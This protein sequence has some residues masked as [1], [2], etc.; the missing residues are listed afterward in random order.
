MTTVK[1]FAQL[2]TRCVDYSKY[3]SKLLVLRNKDDLIEV[4]ELLKI[5]KSILKVKI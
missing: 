5:M 2:V 1:A 3:K 4:Y